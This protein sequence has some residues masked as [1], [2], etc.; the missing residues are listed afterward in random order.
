MKQDT[1]AISALDSFVLGGW[2]T[3]QA[4]QQGKRFPAIDTTKPSKRSATDED[5]KALAQH[6]ADGLRTLGKFGVLDRLNLL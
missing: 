5:L 3:I 1:N 2:E 4:M 6:G